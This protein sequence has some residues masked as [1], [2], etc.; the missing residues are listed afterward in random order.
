VQKHT[1]T[2]ECD[3]CKKTVGGEVRYRGSE[4]MPDDWFIL[5][6][7]ANWRPIDS[8]FCSVDCLYEFVKNWRK[9]LQQPSPED[10]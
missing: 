4:P 9:S 10:A 2:Y 6:Q 8:Y 3:R 1:T 7:N 5:G